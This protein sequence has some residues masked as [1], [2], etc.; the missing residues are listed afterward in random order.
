MEKNSAPKNRVPEQVKPKP[1]QLASVTVSETLA[2]DLSTGNEETAQIDQKGL[3]AEDSSTP[4]TSSPALNLPAP[5]DEAKIASSSPNASAPHADSA[6]STTNPTT[7]NQIKSIS[8]PVGFVSLVTPAKKDIAVEKPAVRVDDERSNETPAATRPSFQP[9]YAKGN[10]TRSIELESQSATAFDIPGTIK[11]VAVQDEDV[12]RALY[13]ERTIS[14]V[15]D[16]SGS[17][18]VQIWTGENK[19]VPQLVK[20]TVSQPWQKPTSTPSDMRDVRQV[21]AQAFPSANVN[22]ITNED[23]TMEVRGT[24][25]TEDQAVRILE[26]VRKLCLV[27]VKDKVTVSR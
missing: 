24:A 17:T 4:G 14:F 27:P 11:S 19:D 2:L 1:T 5:S 10:L 6:A 22:I 8:S 9:R 15:G 13:N 21:I 16:K 23:G 25:D 20:V 12:C 3:L 18:L 7:G 26:I